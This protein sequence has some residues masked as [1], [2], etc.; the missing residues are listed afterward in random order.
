M[1]LPWRNLSDT[2]ST[3]VIHFSWHPAVWVYVCESERHRISLREWM[4]APENTLLFGWQSQR[5]LSSASTRLHLCLFPLSQSWT[6]VWLM[7]FQRGWHHHGRLSERCWT[8][9]EDRKKVWCK[10]KGLILCL[11]WLAELLGFFLFA[12]QVFEADNNIGVKRKLDLKVFVL[13]IGRG[14]LS[15]LLKL[16]C[17]EPSPL[18]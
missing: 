16:H 10:K 17:L 8:H 15:D 3:H 18:R 4:H 5:K 7:G 9:V 6:E 11:R 12:Q 13:C 2:C 14:V 1:Q